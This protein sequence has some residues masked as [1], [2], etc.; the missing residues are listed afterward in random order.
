MAF[1]DLSSSLLFFIKREQTFEFSKHAMSSKLCF[2]VVVQFQ[3]KT[4]LLGFNSF[5]SSREY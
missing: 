3:L 2:N 1:T 4:H 5:Q